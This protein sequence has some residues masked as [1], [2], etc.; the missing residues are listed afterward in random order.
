M[1]PV[2]ESQLL[3][4]VRKRDEVIECLLNKITEK[5]DIE[6]ELGVSRQTVGRALAELEAVGAVTRSQGSCEVTLY[7]ALAYDE[8][9]QLMTQYTTLSAVKPL[10]TPLLADTPLPYRVFAEADI[11]PIDP[12][13]PYEPFTRLAD[14]IRAS[15]Q[16]S[17]HLSVVSPQ[18]IELLTEQICAD[19]LDVEFFVE[20]SL[21]EKLRLCNS[22][23][24]SSMLNDDGCTI[25]QVEEELTFSLVLIDSEEIWLY[26]YTP[27]HQILGIIT[28]RSQAA[29]DWA[30]QL[31]QYQHEQATRLMVRESNDST[32]SSTS[33]IDD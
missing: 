1:S 32:L 19:A 6:S 8:Y 27:D 28:N 7:G 15:E 17:A 12:Q 29:V 33:S 25:W 11:Q 31:F 14:R 16:I 21:G 30:A 20:T 13:L 18:T 2:D 24:M 5:R 3:D 9:N 26:V 22:E 23:F 10:L 4:V